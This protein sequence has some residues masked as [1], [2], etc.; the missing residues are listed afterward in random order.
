MMT[1]ICS[2]YCKIDGTVVKCGKFL[3]RKKSKTPGIS[4]GSCKE[5]FKKAMRVVMQSRRIQQAKED[6]A[7]FERFKKGGD[8][9]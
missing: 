1:V 8:Y 5:C 2:G 9:V 3:G 7:Q 6:I 4:D